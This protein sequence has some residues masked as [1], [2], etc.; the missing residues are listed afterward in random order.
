MQ[1]RLVSLDNEGKPKDVVH[2]GEAPDVW[3][4]PK[5]VI[6]IAGDEITVS[7]N[8]DCGR[9]LGEKEQGYSI[10]FPSFQRIREDKDVQQIT[11]SQEVQDIYHAQG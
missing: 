10:R 8:S 11:T 3:I 4:I 7:P 1:Q 2:T 9:D 6:E 5:I